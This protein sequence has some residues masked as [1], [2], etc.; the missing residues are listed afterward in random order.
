[1]SA[2]D[3]NGHGEDGEVEVLIH[4]VGQGFSS[5]ADGQVKPVESL[6]GIALLYGID[7]SRLLRWNGGR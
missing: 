7:V 3:E 4:Q 5:R 1:M 6:A 2:V